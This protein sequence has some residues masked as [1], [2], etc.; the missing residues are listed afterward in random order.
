[1]SVFDEFMADAP[2]AKDKGELNAA[3]I[4]AMRKLGFDRLNVA[5]MRDI[6]LPASQQKFAL[7]CDYPA[8][9]LRQYQRKNYIQV[10][11]VALSAKSGVNPFF[12]DDLIKTRNLT[13]SQVAVLGEAREA[14]LFHGVGLPFRGAPGLRGG[15]ALAV[16]QPDIEHSTNL[17][18][19]WAMS[20]V[21]YLMFKHVTIAEYT[22]T[23]VLHPRESQV[24]DLV[25]SGKTNQQISSALGNS[26]HT[27]NNQVRQ[28]FSKFGVHS[29]AEAIF[30]AISYGI[31][32]P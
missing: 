9:W 1:M 24:A 32:D 25:F 10:D 14:K 21:Y 19:L 17:G 27:V 7:I 2:S 8:E 4:K 11:P 16:S 3:L 29:R 28:I 15:I 30:R 23:L 5:T 26:P 22:K 13:K 12:W 18:L 20:N 31:Y 6:E